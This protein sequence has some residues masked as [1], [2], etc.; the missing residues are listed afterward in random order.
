M[1][2]K[3]RD[4]IRLSVLRICKNMNY[5]SFIATIVFTITLTEG[6]YIY[7]KNPE[8]VVNRLFLYMTLCLCNWLL[9]AALGYSAN[10]REEVFFFYKL[11]SSGFIFLHAF[12]LHFTLKI[13]EIHKK[14]YLKKL[15]FF[16]YLP[17]FYFLYK[18]WTGILVYRD[19]IKTEDLWI[20]I[21]D[22]G[23]PDLSLLMLNYIS[24]YTISI[25]LLFRWKNQTKSLR[26]KKQALFLVISMMASI[27]LF[28]LEPFILPLLTNWQSIAISPIFGIIWISGVG[29]AVARYRFLS[30]KP[31][32]V[33]QE[34]L[35]NLEE[36][37]IL[38]DT[39]YSPLFLNRAAEILFSSSKDDS[40]PG[41]KTMSSETEMDVRRIIDLSPSLSTD[42][43]RLTRG[44]IQ[45]FSCRVQSPGSKQVYL[46]LKLSLIKDVYGD[47]LGISL[48][49]RQ[50][51]DSIRFRA[52][53][54]LTE[55]E[56]EVLQLLI[57]G[58]K[59]KEIAGHLG[60]SL[61]TVKY[62]NSSIYSKLQVRN[63]IELFR[64]L[65]TYKLFPD[66]KTESTSF[67][68]LMKNRK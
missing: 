10:T 55:R 54:P 14:D 22:L 11:S 41:S 39:D 57:E 42:L 56:T 34:I 13:T 17:S 2:Q 51:N 31:E 7:L 20:A 44:E 28:N 53:F 47:N 19:F 3:K 38:L 5:L 60:I 67:P 59:G 33:S 23:S 15:L 64:M 48:L 25:I 18:S 12:T 9:G 8:S 35:N 58:K 63:R 62:H 24:Y 30:W 27:I 68:L 37:V 26:E 36:P 66:Q 49:G 16:I 40:A 61:R 21:P 46:D 4:G 52:L 45:D 29:Y 1:K 50:I 32:N 43:E 6:I 65:E